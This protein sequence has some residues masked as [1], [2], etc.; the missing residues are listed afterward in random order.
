MRKNTLDDRTLYSAIVQA[1]EADRREWSPP[2]YIGFEEKC[3]GTTHIRRLLL[4]TLPAGHGVRLLRRLRRC[5]SCKNPPPTLGWVTTPRQVRGG[6]VGELSSDLRRHFYRRS[7]LDIQRHG[8]TGRG[9]ANG[10]KHYVLRRSRRLASKQGA[11]LQRQGTLAFG[12]V[13]VV[14]GSLCS[15]LSGIPRGQTSVHWGEIRS[16]VGRPDLRFLPLRCRLTWAAGLVG[17][18]TH[19]DTVQV[20]KLIALW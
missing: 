4:A 10:P 11:R 20:V 2:T 19:N 3:V 17:L 15:P 14:S 5:N 8:W 6:G 13:V 16:H 7:G 18:G 1:H 9:G 12:R